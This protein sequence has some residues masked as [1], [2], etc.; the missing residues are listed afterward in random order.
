MEEKKN[1]LK[2]LMEN[3]TTIFTYGLLAATA[4]G[5]LLGSLSPDHISAMFA[6]EGFFLTG[7]GGLS[8]E[9]LLQFFGLSVVIGTLLLIFVS[10]FF[11]SKYMLV[12]R[13]L[14]FLVAAVM[15]ISLF[16][17][18][19][20]WFPPGVWHGW[21][22][23][24]VGFVVSSSVSMIPTFIKIKREDKEYEKALSNY[25]AKQVKE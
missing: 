3:I 14:I 13:Y 6:T 1:I 20:R 11:L 5:W 10:D 9:S 24:L 7:L 17:L 22:A 12:W 25:K 18:I 8:Y 19:F 21:A 16:V 15:A 2:F 23:L 4:S